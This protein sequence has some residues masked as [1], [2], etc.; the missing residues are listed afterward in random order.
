MLLDVHLCVGV[1]RRPE[2]VRLSSLLRAEDGGEV[3]ASGGRTVVPAVA[4]EAQSISIAKS[5]GPLSSC[6]R[7]LI[8]TV[9]SIGVTNRVRGTAV[10]KGEARG[11][12]KGVERFG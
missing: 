3:V 5:S 8:V 12:R 11:M 9:A 7:K 10:E 1:P 6:R 4:L 2:A